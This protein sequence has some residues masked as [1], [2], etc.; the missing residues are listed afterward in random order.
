[1]KAETISIVNDLKKV[2]INQ[3]AYEA[4]TNSIH[5]E[6]TQIDLSVIS[7]NSDLD[8]VENQFISEIKLTDNGHGFKTEDLDSFQTYRSLHKK[9]KFGAK[10]VGRFL[11]LKLFNNVHIISLGKEIKFNI[12]DDVVVS[13]SE[14]FSNKTCLHINSPKD[15]Y[16]VNKKDFVRSIKLHFLPLFKL[17]KNNTPSKVVYIT[18]NFNGKKY[19]TIKSDDIPSFEE[20]EFAIDDHKFKISYLLN[21]TEYKSGD[22]AYCADGR[23]VCFNS[24]MEPNKRFK[25]FKGINFFY[26]LSASYF[27]ENLND[28]RDD[29]TINAKRKSQK[30]WLS[31]LSWEDIHT[32]LGYKIKDICLEHGINIESQSDENLKKAVDKAPFLSSYFKQNEL[33]LHEEDLLKEAQKAFN[34]DKEKIRADESKISASERKIVLNRVVQAELAEYVF[35]RQKTINKLKALEDAN[36]LEKE[37]HNLFIERFTQN[38]GGDYR[39]NNL[40]LFDD[41]FMSYDKVFSDKQIKDIFPQLNDH[42]DKPD[43]LSIASNT[44]EKNEITDI[45]IIELK[46]PEAQNDVAIAESELLKYSRYTIASGLSNIRIWTYAFI[47]FDK[48]SDL[49]LDD[50]SYNKIP[51][52]NGWP[53]RYRYHERL[54]TIINF[55][56]YKA[57]AF[58]AESRNNTFLNILKAKH[59][60]KPTN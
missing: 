38:D 32:S 57:L 25:A 5:A 33:M 60:S 52:Q 1:M 22:G 58:D 27:D 7:L 15:G 18:I 30:N 10:G 11:F 41:R 17:I 39:T 6:A 55:I 2:T 13:N 28:E 50:K 16:Q 24:Q 34:D 14:S 4:I 51:V 8:D 53:I 35:D 59:Y 9:T 44:F 49:A 21:H 48:E 36:A 37:I 20:S 47:S 12:G 46:R 43:I 56:D 31:T 26:L 19:T 29:L 42:L 3:V 23:V 40:W 45:V 54:N